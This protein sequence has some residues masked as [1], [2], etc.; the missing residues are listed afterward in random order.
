MRE[1]LDFGF[2][3]LDSG[4]LKSKIGNLKSKMGHGSVTLILFDVDGTLTATTEADA[5]CYAAAFEKTFGLPLPT[6][7]WSVYEH[8]TDFAIAREVLVSLRGTAPSVQ[9]CEAFERA[10]VETLEDGGIDVPEFRGE[11]PE[12]VDVHVRV[13]PGFIAAPDTHLAPQ[14]AARGQFDLPR[15]ER[16]PANAGEEIVR[17]R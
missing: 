17:V 2:W 12:T 9:E 15:P 4:R 16:P 6:M 7:D 11:R 8:C 10:F 1:I 13:L 14:R 5:K 3:I